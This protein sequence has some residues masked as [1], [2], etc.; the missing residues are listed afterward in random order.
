MLNRLLISCFCLFL[1]FSSV[2]QLQKDILPLNR[3]FKRGG[4]FISPEATIS[5]GNKV[6]NEINFSDSSYSYEDIG[7]GIWRYGISLGWFHSFKRKQPIQFLEGSISYRVFKGETEHSGVLTESNTTSNFFSENIYSNQYINLG[8][9]AK[10]F[11]QLGTFTFL[12]FGLG[13]NYYQEIANDYSRSSSYPQIEEEFASEGN[14]QIHFQVGVGFKLTDKLILIPTIETP[15]LTLIPSD[16]LNPAWPFFNAN[17]QPF[18]IGFQ[19]MFLRE[20]PLNCNA[21]VLR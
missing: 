16:Q 18:V 9:R 4:F 6:G 8:L 14:F 19:L 11:K 12:T 7:R 15:L 5:I 10:S 21:P 2:A 1:S 20:D 17:Y 13:L 3:E